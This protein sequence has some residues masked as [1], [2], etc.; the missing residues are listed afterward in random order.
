MGG[1]ISLSGTE[2]VIPA[3]LDEVIIGYKT[4]Q[5]IGWIE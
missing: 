5:E 4:G 1:R 3:S 2:P